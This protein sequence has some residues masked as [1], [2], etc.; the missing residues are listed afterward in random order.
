MKLT[1]EEREALDATLRERCGER[2]AYLTD[3]G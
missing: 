2:V 3:L 1:P